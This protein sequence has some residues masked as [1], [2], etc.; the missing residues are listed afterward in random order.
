[1]ID[2]PLHAESIELLIEE[3][4]SELAGEQR[5]VF[6]DRQ[7]DAPLVVLRQFHDRRQKRLRQLANADHFIHAVQ[8][9]DDVQTDLW[10]MKEGVEGDEGEDLEPRIKV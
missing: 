3:L 7:A 8:I 10:K 2:E 1:M 9:R 6:D 5:H 4:D